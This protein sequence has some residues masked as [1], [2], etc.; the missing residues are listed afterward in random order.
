MPEGDN[1]EN[2]DAVDETHA[3][4]DV[5][6][7]TRTGEDEVDRPDL[8]KNMVDES[9]TGDNVVDESGSGAHDKGYDF[10]VDPT[11]RSRSR[12]SPSLIKKKVKK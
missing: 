5:V 1:E 2:D 3:C 12:W 8:D 10:S 9:S 6:D 11:H 7:E 4:E